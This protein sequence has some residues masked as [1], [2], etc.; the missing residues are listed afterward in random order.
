MLATVKGAAL[1]GLLTIVVVGGLH[2]T[3][4]SADPG[5]SEEPDAYQGVVQREVADHHCSYSGFGIST[6]PSSAL[7]RNARGQLRR[8]SFAVG[9]EVYSGRRPGTLVAVCLDRPGGLV[10]VNG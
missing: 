4:P 7:I 9:W 2:A 3:A 8:V 1:G 5:T 10:Q 6:V